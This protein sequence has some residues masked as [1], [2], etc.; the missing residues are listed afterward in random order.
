MAIREGFSDFM[1]VNEDIRISYF[2][3][4]SPELYDFRPENLI[5]TSPIQQYSDLYFS[6]STFV[7]AV[8]KGITTKNCTQEL[9]TLQGKKIRQTSDTFPVKNGDEV[10]GAI[11][12]AYYD[13][14]YSADQKKESDNE[15]AKAT[16]ITAEDFLG[17][18]AEM[19]ELRKKY[20]KV[21]ALDSPVLI[22]GE[23]GTGKEMS[24]RIIH[25]E[26]NRS[27]K[28]KFVYVNCSTIPENLIEGILFGIQPGSFTDAEEK[29]GLFEEA[30]GG[31]L[32]LDELDSTPLI[33]QGKIL[34]AIE[35]RR[36]RPVGADREI[37]VDI[38]IIASCNASPEEIIRD[39]KIRNDLYYR[40]SVVQFEL[41]P[42]RE[43]REDIGILCKAFI[44]E[45]NEMNTGKKIEN[46]DREFMDFAM[47]YRWP[48]NVRELKNVIAGAYCEA[49]GKTIKF[50][51]IRERFSEMTHEEEECLLD[52]FLGS[53]MEL[54]DFIKTKTVDYIKENI[55][56]C[57]GDL[58]KA[59]KKMNVSLKNLIYNIEKYEIRP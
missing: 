26:S 46:V 14:N 38:R 10:I 3:I 13:F 34:R 9:T 16:V 50:D 57:E 28:G 20:R 55:D 1:I 12:F 5:G 17:K 37:P 6:D 54:K 45:M 35:E 31:T 40:L 11:E 49:S 29:K 39:S 51:D 21:A 25:N 22:T 15:F 48:G 8:S 59:A 30:S 23:T 24:A 52:E 42:L 18:T 47:N 7:K 53:E 2:Y 58:K 32:F 56:Y 27:E 36:I 33:T 19:K 4:P 44:D 43:K 41:P